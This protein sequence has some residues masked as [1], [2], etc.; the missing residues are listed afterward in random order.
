M[1]NEVDAEGDAD[2][3]LQECEELVDAEDSEE[4]DAPSVGMASVYPAE[5]RPAPATTTHEEM[6]KRL[7]GPGRPPTRYTQGRLVD[8]PL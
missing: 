1:S 2:Y 6:V 4:S 7:R 8:V 3:D 5:K